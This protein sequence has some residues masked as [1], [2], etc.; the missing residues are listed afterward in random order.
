MAFQN[1]ACGGDFGVEGAAAGTTTVQPLTCKL[2]V[3]YICPYR[4]KFKFSARTKPFTLSV[5]SSAPQAQPAATGFNMDYTQ[6]FN[7]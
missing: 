5:F 4:L 1:V 2:K 6:V 7:S 3:T